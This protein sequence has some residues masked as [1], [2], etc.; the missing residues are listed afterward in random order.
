MSGKTEYA[1]SLFKNAL[2]LK[3]GTLDT[4]PDTLRAFDRDANDAII[5]DDIR[6]MAFLG[7]HQEKLQG[8]PP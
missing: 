6:D 5:L 3:I 4:F 8:P 2:Q 7:N 1:Q